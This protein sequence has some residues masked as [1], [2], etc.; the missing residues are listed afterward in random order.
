M[1]P[2]IP[3]LHSYCF[4]PGCQLPENPHNN[5]FCDSC[6]ANLLLS[7]RYRGLRL[8][9]KGGSG[10]TFLVLDFA[11]SPGNLCVIKQTW[12]NFPCYFS[13]EVLLK[14]FEFMKYSPHPPTP[15]PT[16]E[17]EK[18]PHHNEYNRYHQIPKYLE[19]FEQNEV[20]YQVQEYI[21]G[22]NLAKILT[23]KITFNIEEIC[24]ILTSL[25]PVIDYIHNCGI[26]H[27]DIKPE[28]IIIRD[29]LENLVLVDI[30][31]F[32]PISSKSIP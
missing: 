7:D 21:L 6:G 1:N 19:Q 30:G 15:T 5:L 23:E 26:I 8:L 24:L 25:L 11:Q 10:Q 18:F 27:Y 16:G 2:K 22:D 4:N 14:L 31:G 3:D 9:G 29:N 17:G 28:N 13:P 12:G 20:F 32:S